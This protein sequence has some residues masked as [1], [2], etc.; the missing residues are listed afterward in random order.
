MLLL[1]MDLLALGIPILC[2]SRFQ[3]LFSVFLAVLVYFLMEE[4]L[5]L[6]Y[7]AAALAALIPLYI[8][9]TF[10]RS[11]DAAYLTAV[12]E[13]KQENLPIFVT[14]PYMYVA[15]NYDNFD[16]LV[17]GLEKF[18]LGKKMLTPVWT[19]TGLKFLFPSLM[20]APIFVTKQELTTLTLYYD[21][22]CDF[23]LLGVAVLAGL[24]GAVSYWLMQGIRRARNPMYYLL[25]AQ[26]AVY[27]MLSFFT[28]WFSNP[29][30]WFYLA[31]TALMAVAVS[32]RWGS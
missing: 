8:L 31:V 23:G 27:L 21:A 15:N 3:L 5:N 22:Y 6:F 14:Q 11:H 25:Y 26:V 17:K 30:T 32:R 16:C 1:L 9:L 19:L 28:T 24:L 7:A 2:V 20:E 13:M 29:T 12:F 18:T 4:R 10:A